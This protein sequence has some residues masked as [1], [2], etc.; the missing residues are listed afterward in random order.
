MQSIPQ[1][2]E[3]RE[4]EVEAARRISQALFQ[5]LRVED[6]VEQA[7]D[8]ALEVVNADA[9]S[10]LLAHPESQQLVF[11][12]AIG[13]KSPARGTAFPWDQGIA[14]T[15]FQTGEAVVVDNAKQDAR[16][17]IGID[18]AF[19]HITQ[20]LIALPLK[21]WEGDPIGVL[22]VMNKK[23]GRLDKDDVAILTIIS[24]ITAI[25]IEQA[26][27][28]EEV[29]VAQVAH[30]LGDISHD[31]KNMMMPIIYG[32]WLLQNKNESPGESQS[33]QTSQQLNQEILSMIRSNARCIQNR[34]KEITDA[35][36]GLSSPPTFRCCQVSEIITMVI[37]TLRLLAEEKSISLQSEDLQ[38]L[39]SIQADERRLFN[40][41]YNLISNAIDEVSGGG[42]VTI[43]G[44]VDPQS[45]TIVVSVQDTGQG[46]PPEVQQS[47]FTSR[48]IS[49]KTGGTGLGTKIV[50]DVIDAHGGKI[51]VDSQV[52]V[53][54]T[55]HIRL[56]I[57]PPTAS[58]T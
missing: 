36:K 44:A 15:T 42:C 20:D 13:E 16:H 27:L 41:F 39:P 37:Q 18:V 58:I 32:A 50:K 54:S 23:S 26:R 5:R 53:G 55:F 6:V 49:R 40:A 30:L 8:I 11:Y 21:R 28:F 14:G 35:V 12:H 25:S 57:H 46:M 29:K 9:G 7:L 45:R 3:R 38:A 33:E 52:G 56:P 10:V 17:F 34:V 22:E 51:T 4:R 43:R 31:I 48:V 19:G 1:R 24:A 47:L 2:L